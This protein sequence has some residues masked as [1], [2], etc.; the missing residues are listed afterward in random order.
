MERGNK[1]WVEVEKYPALVG[2]IRQLP[3]SGKWTQA[4]KA[5]F[6]EVFRVVLNLYVEV[7]DE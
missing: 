6:R 4:Q 5:K 1:M 7:T 2:M 3:P